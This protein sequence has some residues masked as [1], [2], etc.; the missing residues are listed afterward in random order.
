M[1]VT[2]PDGEGVRVVRCP[3]P[4]G[5]PPDPP[6]VVCVHGWGCSAFSF[7]QVL[8]R[9][10][11]AGC[12]VFA[13]DVRGHGWS[14]KPLDLA[15]Y[16][17]DALG[18]WLVDVL[19]A[20]G[21]ERAVLVGHSM[22]GAVVL[23]AALQAPGRIAGLVQLAPVGFGDIPRTRL[24]RWLT[25]RLLDPLLPY[26]ARRA[27]IGVGLRTGYGAIGAPC[28]RDLDEYWAPT[29]DP[30]FARAARLV[31]HAFEWAPGE[32]DVLARLD[33]PVHVLLGERDNLVAAAHVRAHAAGPPSLRIDEVP[34]AG[35]VLPEE[36]PDVVV[37][38]V[39]DDAHA[40]WRPR[41]EAR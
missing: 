18:R 27:V 36:V 7:N 26:L 6:V 4:A 20:L 39:V 23:R 37:R 1:R 34:R 9:I 33:C 10:A 8:R 24:L 31:A 3:P 14:D 41:P 13:P 19:D 2:L 21:V 30:R 38:T 22:G 11:D 28:E 32:P 25:P 40:W 35:H 17:P 12:D 15:C 29:A 16:T 5:T